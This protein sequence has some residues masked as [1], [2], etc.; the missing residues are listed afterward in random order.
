MLKIG[1]TGGL[2]SGKTTVSQAFARLG[3]QVIDTDEISHELTAAN[4]KAIAAIRESFG[5]AV[6]S[7]D[8][9]LARAVLRARI[10]ADDNA[11]RQLEAILHPLIRHE[12]L[13]RLEERK[14]SYV[15]IVIPL[16]VETGAY[17]DLLNR[18][19]VVD[20]SEETQVRRALARGGWSEA[21]IR[22]M[23]ARQAGRK[24]RLHRADDVINS[25]C[26]RAALSSQVAALDQ[27]YRALASQML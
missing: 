1:L 11:K 27:K 16:L 21:E 6:F 17:D 10:L 25:D 18:V 3:A 15:L 7:P 19:L 12:V 8:G 4:G 24:T 5:D 22:A 14:A 13:T 9:T 26:E 2:G 20:C 23:V